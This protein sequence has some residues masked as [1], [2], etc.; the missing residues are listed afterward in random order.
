MLAPLTLHSS[1]PGLLGPLGIATF[2]TNLGSKAAAKATVLRMTPQSVTFEVY[3]PDPVLRLS[4]VL[5]EFEI[6][7]E[8]RPVYA[9]KALVTAIFNTGT[10]IACEAALSPPLPGLNPLDPPSP[11]RICRSGFP[12]FLARWQAIY[13]VNSDYKIV[14]ADLESFLSNLRLWL[15]QVELRLQSASP[16]D[17]PRLEAEVAQGLRAPVTA[18]VSNMF[19]RFEAVTAQIEPELLPAHRAFGQRQ[20]HPHLLCSPFIH[21]TFVK[22]LGY[23]GDYEMMNMIV[24]NGLEGPSL[25]AKLVNGYLLD[26]VGP[27]A[28]R[29]RVDYLF[30]R[31]ADETCRVAR[32]GRRARVFNI[33]CG[34]VRE[35]Q[36]FLAQHP[37]AER[38][39]F[40]LLDFDEETLHYA[41]STLRQIKQTHHLNTEVEL[42]RKS[43]QQML[44]ANGAPVAPELGYDLIYC[45]GLYDYLNDRV[46]RALNNYL[47]DQ[48][49]PGGLL[50]V[51][52]FAPN[53]PVRNFIEHFLEWF[54]IYRD[55]QQLARLAPAQAS[56]GDCRVVAEPTGTNLF[57]EV[58]K[59]L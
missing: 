12:L 19:E 17:R 28:V 51:G 5:N 49:R 6:F 46:I 58:R 38:A 44:R 27:Q 48:L 34:P 55:A 21:R 59:P 23:A 43:V 37:L 15:E 41:G 29:N 31:I 33:A 20:L 30:G 4:E 22:P 36:H 56:P 7:D 57:L 35:I 18:C 2:K 47:Y 40:H 8:T 24:R 14:I 3:G 52:N 42:V 32:L 1:E 11:E 45:S 50:T 25:Y 10:A 53:M 26:Q 13:R 54:L 39:E 9:G 16:A